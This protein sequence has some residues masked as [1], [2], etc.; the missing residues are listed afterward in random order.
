MA[1]KGRRN[2]KSKNTVS[3]QNE[4]VVHECNTGEVSFSDDNEQMVAGDE[5]IEV[6]C[7][8]NVDFGVDEK[9][10]N[11][12][13]MEFDYYKQQL[14]AE[15]AN[16]E[17]YMH[18]AQ[19]LQ[20]DF[21]NYRKRNANIAKE[22]KKEGIC[23]SVLE[24]LPAYDALVEGLKMVSDENVKKGLEMVERVFIQSLANLGIQPI[25]SLEQ[26]FDPKLHNVI[27]TEEVEGVE[28]GTIVQEL[29]KG[30]IDSEGNVVRVATVKTAK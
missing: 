11:E 10:I 6:A 29:S 30:F 9:E 26:Q 15:R 12:Q 23:D 25:Q 21:D 4:E 18:M 20:A 8:D 28:S 5:N 2:Y 19:Q 3:A 16:M 22:S 14:E 17:M 7:N 27:L 13:A 1:K 24:L